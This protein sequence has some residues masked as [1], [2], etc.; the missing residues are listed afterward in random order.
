MLKN[1]IRKLLLAGGVDPSLI[2]YQYLL[3]G[4]YLCYDDRSLLQHTTD[5]LY[6]IIAEEHGTKHTIVR[7]CMRYAV[8]NMEQTDCFWFKK[9]VVGLIDDRC[10]LTNSQFIAICVEI[11]KMQEDE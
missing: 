7:R 2:G 11:L 3:T 10:L 8:E 1:R 4:I 6:H 9:E 5:K